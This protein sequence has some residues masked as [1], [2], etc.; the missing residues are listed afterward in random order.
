[1]QVLLPFIYTCPFALQSP[2]QPVKVESMFGKA[3]AVAVL[4][5]LYVPPP[6]TVPVPL[7][8]VLTVTV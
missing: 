5:Q 2:L 6:E 1:M 4:P 7:P 8:A 3:L